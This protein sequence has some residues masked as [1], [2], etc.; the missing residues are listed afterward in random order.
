LA[1][2]KGRLDNAVRDAHREGLTNRQL[3]HAA[4]LTAREVR[5]I[6]ES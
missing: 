4:G 6:L 2:A 1:D 3:A 5:A